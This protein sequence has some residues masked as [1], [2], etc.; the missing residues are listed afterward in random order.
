MNYIQII[1]PTSD[2][3]LQETLIAVLDIIDFDGFEESNENLKA[4]IDEDKFDVVA[5]DEIM[6]QFGLTYSKETITKQNWNELWESN[7][8]PVLVD[9]FVGIRADFHEPLR[10]GP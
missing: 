8:E 1:V 7:F 3:A 9:D 2:T 6:K 4:F 5:V 10:D